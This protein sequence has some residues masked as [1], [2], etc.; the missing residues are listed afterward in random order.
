MPGMELGIDLGTSQVVITAAGRGILLREPRD[1]ERKAL[2]KRRMY[3]VPQRGQQGGRQRQGITWFFTPGTAEYTVPGQEPKGSV[4]FTAGGAGP[5]VGHVAAVTIKLNKDFRTAYY[6]GGSQV[7][8][9]LVTYV[10]KNRLGVT[11]GTMRPKA[12]HNPTDFPNS[13]YFPLDEPDTT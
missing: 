13:P 2:F 11:R 9:A 8:P 5:E 1:L 6:H 10:R 7:H 3:D 12:A 4:G